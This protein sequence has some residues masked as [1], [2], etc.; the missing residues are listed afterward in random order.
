MDNTTE[1][2]FGDVFTDA[3]PTFDP[4][5]THKVTNRDPRI[6]KSTAVLIPHPSLTLFPA[7]DIQNERK[8]IAL[9]SD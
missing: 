7:H 4:I 1:V 3:N 9:F 6:I 8:V 2:V 5:E